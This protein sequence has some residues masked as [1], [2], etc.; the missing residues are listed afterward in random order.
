MTE[1]ISPALHAR[2]EDAASNPLRL[3]EPPRF[4]CGS[5]LECVAEPVDAKALGR[6]LSVL[7][8]HRTP[9]AILGAET[10]SWLGNPIRSARVGVST[11]CL[12]GIDEFDEAD[13]VVRVGAGMSLDTLAESTAR[14]G[15]LVPIDS[16]GRGGTVGGALATGLCGPRRIGFGPVR[17]AV[18][19]L[20]TVLAEGVATRCG[21]RVVKNVTGY[22]MA[23]LYVGSLGTL[24]VIE[25]AWLRL[26]AA[27]ETARVFHASVEGAVHAEGLE[28][29]RRT[30]AR[31]VVIVD[32]GLI[33]SSGQSIGRPPRSA[34]R[35][36]LFVEFA[37]DVPAVDRDCEWVANELAAEPAPADTMGSVRD[38]QIFKFPIGVRVRFH[39]LPSVAE[40]ALTRLERGGARCLICPE[41]SVITAWFEAGLDEGEDPWWLDQVFAVI[42]EVRSRVGGEAVIEEI[43][44]W[45]RGRRD[46][47]GGSPV[48]GLMRELKER[49]DPHGILN[50]GRFV[51][52]L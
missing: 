15:W 17:D 35:H 38:L 9:A 36:R 3:H 5:S 33:E 7:E 25:R 34:V 51:G 16:P 45:A 13:G 23:K 43:P 11:S 37:G 4:Y 48:L 32:E 42:E 46:V 44:D 20:E 28:V 52:N 22:D 30:T 50:P 8:S 1:R 47:F 27:P 24:G 19:G 2:L 18:L 49:F 14:R 6:V 41:P 31:S 39:T 21:A 12:S 29:A 10:R 40:E 26:R